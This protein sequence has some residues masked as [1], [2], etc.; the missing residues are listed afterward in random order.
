MNKKDPKL[1][2]LL[3]NECIN[4]QDIG[5]LC[6]FMAEDVK[7]IMG[8]EVAQNNKEEAKSAWMQFFEMCP[9]YKNHFYRIESEEDMPFTSSGLI[10]DIIV[11]P[12][13]VPSRQT[14]GQLLEIL[15][16]KT[17]ALDG[18][19]VDGSAFTGDSEEN[20]K[21]LLRSLGFRGDGKEVMYNG[22]TGEKYDIEIF[23]GMVYYQKLDHMVANKIQARSRGPVT[24]LTRQPTE[25]K[26]K[27]G[28]LRLGEMEKDCFVAHGASLLMK[29][30]F[31]SD[32]AELWICAKCGNIATYDFYKN[33]AHCLC[34]EKTK[35]HPVE[36]SYA[37]NLF[38]NELKSM[39]I[40]P[41]LILK[42]KY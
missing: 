19:K 23:T 11:N 29:E 3:F 18:K 1:T 17:T 35:V 38:L 39:H 7:L 32:R 26:A 41:N 21:N 30:R 2:V 6:K 12:H 20:I 31:D 16:G 28:G 14:V 24:L 22:I 25:G 4:N 10:P 40:K 8:N 34:G 27:E 5:G 15:A 13:S 36:M 9:D 37:F 42:D 33:K